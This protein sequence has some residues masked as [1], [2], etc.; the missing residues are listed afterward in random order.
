MSIDELLLAGFLPCMT[1]KTCNITIRTFAPITI[2]N[3]DGN[4]NTI[5]FS[6]F[7]YSSDEEHDQS[8]NIKNKSSPRIKIDNIK[9]SHNT[10]SA[11]QSTS[12]KPLSSIDQYIKNIKYI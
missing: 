4:G 10:P 1:K 12:T 2:G 8:T 11:I 5:N 6:D 9:P 3:I 7:E